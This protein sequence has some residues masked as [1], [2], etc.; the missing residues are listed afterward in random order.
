M[1]VTA[2]LVEQYLG[3][4][5]A[6]GLKASTNLQNQWALVRLEK[7]CPE[8]P[9]GTPDL[10]PIFDQPS[11]GLE[12]RR[13]LRKCLRTFFAWA[14]E[15]YSIPDPCKGLGRFPKSGLLP[16]ILTNDELAQLLEAAELP[17]DRA[18]L[19]TTLD[20]GLRLTEVAGLKRW[21]IRDGWLVVE[22][23]SGA[24]QVPVSPEVSE[25]L[26]DIGE[27]EYVWM[28]RQG[29][30]TRYGVQQV[31]KRMFIRA[32]VGGRKA[33]P[34]A[35]R[36]TF[37]TLYLRAGGGVHHLQQILGHRSIET[38]MIYVHLAG[39]DVQAD[40]AAYSPVRTLGVFHS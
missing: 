23:K 22:G 1:F 30:L 40:H 28:G 2:E 15:R 21:G 5:K 27:G 4:C 37:A 31:F 19:L 34:H 14:G 9:C 17:R 12:S 8:L 39:N 24:R 6:R 20:C 29:P 33:G 18:L 36:H 35:I 16:R 13:D 11:L 7:H 3:E 32:G 26:R 38:T 10:V 25:L